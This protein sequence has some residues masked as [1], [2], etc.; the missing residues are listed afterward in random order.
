MQLTHGFIFLV[1]ILLAL[2]INIVFASL[3]DIDELWMFAMAVW[4]VGGLVVGVTL[5]L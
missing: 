4:T 1:G 2:G 3:F 5:F